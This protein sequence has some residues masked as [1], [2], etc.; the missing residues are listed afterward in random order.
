MLVDLQNPNW[1]ADCN[2]DMGK[3]D[4]QLQAPLIMLQQLL[5]GHGHDHMETG[6]VKLWKA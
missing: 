3:Q 1:E 6:T 2:Q 5:L 4:I